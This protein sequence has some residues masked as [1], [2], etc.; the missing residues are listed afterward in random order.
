MPIFGNFLPILRSYS[1][2]N[3]ELIGR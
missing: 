2:R 3:A 1:G